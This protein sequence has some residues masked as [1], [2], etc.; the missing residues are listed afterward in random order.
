MARH[1]LLMPLAAAVLLAG[2]QT[3]PQ[4]DT[5]VSYVAPST[6]SPA[7][8][9]SVAELKAPATPKKIKHQPVPT[10]SDSFADLK[11]TDNLWDLTRQNFQLQ[12]A[13]KHPA[14]QTQINWYSQY[15]THM[16]RVTENA[17]RYYYYVINEVIKR[18]MPAEIALL[19]AVE[20]MY[21]PSAYS[22]GHAAGIWQF[23][24]S[25]AKYYGIK[26]SNWY[27][28]RRDLIESTQTALDYLQKLNERFEG[29]WLLTM[30]AYN[31]GGGTIS[32]AVRKNQEAGKPTDFWSLSL[33]KETRLYVPRILA[34][35]S[36]VKDPVAHNMD[37]PKID[38]SPYFEMIEARGQINLVDAATETG[39]RL[40]E[41]KLLN[42][43][44]THLATDPTGPHRILVPVD[45]AD[46]LRN[47]LSTLANQ[48]QDRWV[49][50]KVR[51]G[52]TLSTIAARY[53]VQVSL[54][55]DANELVSNTLRIG[56]TLLIPQ[57]ASAGNTRVASHR[58]GGS[59]TG[60]THTVST[61]DTLW[62]IARRYNLTVAQLTNM[63]GIAASSTITAGQRLRVNN[64]PVDLAKDEADAL[65]K[66]GYRVQ[67]GDSLSVIADRYNVKIGDIIA[68]NNLDAESLITPG[69]QLTLFID[70][71]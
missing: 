29:D 27:D 61:G 3:M 59:S 67:S 36:F 28:G 34:I 38:N 69:Q 58:A 54:L 14:V 39:T 33:P 8:S 63:N 21:D 20:S 4:N 45:Q 11:V 22:T 57:P 30:A 71:G 1:F 52:D 55:K 53:N 31:A 49:Q 42:P 35:S 17:A 46:A 40:A 26:R 18:G 50:Y 47:A 5:S 65:R 62:G 10:L 16:R 68:W 19:P 25:T 66:I 64:L 12:D 37:L 56:K 24:P 60:L 51:S 7:R 32:R 48:A 41:L 70:E 6:P 23:I 9:E 15:P 43:G 13:A 44:I 2:C